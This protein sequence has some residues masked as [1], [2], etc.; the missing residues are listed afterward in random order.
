MRP[1]AVFAPAL[2]LAVSLA[3]GCGTPKVLPRVEGVDGHDQVDNGTR[4]GEARLKPAVCQGIDTRPEHR[5][6]DDR[7]IVEFLQQQGVPLRISRAR[8]DLVYVEIQ[9]NP[10]RDQWVRLRVATLPSAPQA[11]EELYTAL[12][13]KGDGFWGVHRSN[14][15]ILGPPG[16]V[17]IIVALAAKTKLACWGVLTVEDSG[18]AS[19]VPGGYREI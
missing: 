16:D 15:A 5:V 17:D 6:L 8:A 3:L 10:G 14:L 7:A 2:A 4:L 1:A 12:Q 19:V 13:Q 9:P 11:G 18:D